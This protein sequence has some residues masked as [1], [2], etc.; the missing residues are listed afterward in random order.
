[1]KLDNPE[2]C[3]L[4]YH[5]RNSGSHDQDS[6]PVCN[7]T[8]TSVTKCMK[9]NNYS[10][11][12]RWNAVKKLPLCRTCLGQHSR[13]C[14]SDT[15]CGITGCKRRHHP[16]LHPKKKSKKSRVA[17]T[18][19][20]KTDDILFP[21]VP[22]KLSFG[23]N[24]TNTF[25]FLDSGSSVS[26]IDKEIAVK[27]N[28]EGPTEDLCLKWTNNVSREEKGSKR[29]SLNISGIND[30]KSYEIKDL[31]TVKKLDLSTQSLNLQEMVENFPHLKN[32]PLTSYKNVQPRVLIGLN[33]SH[34]S[35]PLRVKEG[36][37]NEPI[38][39]KTRIGW[40]V[41]GITNP[42]RKPLNTLNVHHCVHQLSNDDHQLLRV[43]Y[44]S[45]DLDPYDNQG[46]PIGKPSSSLKAIQSN[47]KL[48]KFQQDR[49]QTSMA[50]Y[51]S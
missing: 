3:T 50:S 14:G 13:P 16:L 28:T 23:S 7:K 11:N 41:S 43:T 35:A 18:K 46:R 4:N 42:E 36:D 47:S 2:S 38:A 39:I 37:I 24:S 44:D 10:R 40:T 31:C 30:L 32:L 20:M 34:I 9:F 6:C 51:L 22:V 33:N 1:M 19:P 12:K 48:A 49:F 45:K 29:I 8:C 21:I 26:L 5:N 27:L 17:E 15:I 25:A